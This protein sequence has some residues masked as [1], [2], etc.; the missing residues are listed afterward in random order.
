MSEAAALE[1]A[2]GPPP[3]GFDRWDELL[4]L[5]LDAFACMDGVI[6]PPSSVKRLT[7]ASLAAK[8]R[9]EILL[10][11][12]SGREIVGCVFADERSDC[13]YVGKLAVRPD[14]QRSGL[15]RRLVAAVEQA[16]IRSGKSALELQTRIEL[17]G[18]H[19]A[20]AKMGFR[21]TARTA[22]VGFDRPTS[23]TLRKELPES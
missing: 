10:L 4:A 22:H 23:I 14:L 3:A 21:E 20:F 19:A 17:T 16:A 18:N 9:H 2:I 7:P 6:D 15:G 1:I 5:I 13:L 12:T 11:A 8:A